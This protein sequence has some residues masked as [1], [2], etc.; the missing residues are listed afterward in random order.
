MERSYTT[1]YWTCWKWFSY[2]IKNV[3]GCRKYE[4]SIEERWR[5][6]VSRICRLIQFLIHSSLFSFP[7]LGKQDFLFYFLSMI[8]KFLK[9]IMVGYQGCYAILLHVKGVSLKDIKRRVSNHLLNDVSSP[10]NY[11]NTLRRM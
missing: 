11:Q 3:R 4:T 1:N 5:L 2:D 10:I 9:C 6:Q 8:I 7:F